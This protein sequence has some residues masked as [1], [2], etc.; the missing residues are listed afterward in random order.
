MTATKIITAWS[1]P[2]TQCSSI[3]ELWSLLVTRMRRRGFDGQI[4]FVL[5]QAPNRAKELQVEEDFEFILGAANEVTY[6]GDL[7]GGNK[8]FM[9]YVFQHNLVEKDPIAFH[10]RNHALEI[11]I[12]GLDFLEPSMANFEAAKQYWSAPSKYRLR[13][14]LYVPIVNNNNPRTPHGFGLHS[15]LVGDNFTAMVDEN[16]HEILLDCT[17]FEKY[18]I[19]AY[20][21]HI[22]S[23]IGITARQYDVLKQFCFGFSNREIA[24][25]LEISVPTVSF[26]INALKENLQCETNRELPMTAI[27]LGIVDI[28]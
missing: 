4:V 20:R 26:H 25:V 21:K 3:S 6:F 23:R 5:T 11:A 8:E 1:D 12:L 14:A 22:A 9:E 18:F 28:S 2:F 7:P 16:L 27:R 24:E 15:T 13:N 17:Y 10:A 19:R